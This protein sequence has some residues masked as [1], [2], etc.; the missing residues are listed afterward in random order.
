MYG[1]L[2]GDLPSAKNSDKPG[3]EERKVQEPSQGNAAV[4]NDI[5]TKA[6]VEPKQGSS[7]LSGLGNAGTSMAFVPT[8]LRPRKRPKTM[9]TKPTA[10]PPAAPAA[11]TPYSQQ[12]LTATNEVISQVKPK[13]IDAVT[14]VEDIHGTTEQAPDQNI[15]N[16]YLEQPPN[17]EEED[18]EMHQLHAAVT[19][20]YDPHVPNDL[21]AYWE[22]KKVEEERLRLEREVR[23]TLELQKRLREQL[24]QERVK[25]Q[26]TGS[27]AEI[28]EHRTKTALSGGRGRGVANLPAWLLQK[29]KDE[30][31]GAAPTIDTSAMRTVVLSNLTAPGDIDSELAQEVREECEEQC[32]PVEHVE[33]KDSNPPMQPE[34]QVIVRFLTVG[35]ATKAAQLFHGRLFG[36]RRITATRES[37]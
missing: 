28:I 10:K 5:P 34:V 30:Q 11:S 29:Q 7:I 19:D 37:M 22:R 32:G 36:T 33:V 27:V 35:D 13:A 8:A 4:L 31:L 26:A 14:I 2:F 18:K 16:D 15:P 20:P 1:G 21:L 9:F 24:E 3:G 25:V 17:L 12:S 6:D 23:E